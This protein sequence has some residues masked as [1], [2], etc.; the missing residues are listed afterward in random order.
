MNPGYR[1]TIASLIHKGI[2][3]PS[4]MR[5]SAGSQFYI[6]YCNKSYGH[7]LSVHVHCSGGPVDVLRNYE[8]KSLYDGQ[9]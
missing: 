8:R 7:R 4:Q 5:Q 1:K 9:S 2:L 6:S 3:V